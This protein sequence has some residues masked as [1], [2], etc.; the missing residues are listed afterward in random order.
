VTEKFSSWKEIAAH[1]NITVRTAQRW[2]KSEQLPVHRHL[3]SQRHSVY[4]F[5]SE[6]DEWWIKRGVNL[7]Q[8]VVEKPLLRRKW[9]PFAVLGAVTVAGIGFLIWPR[10]A[11]PRGEVLRAVPL[12]AYR[13]HE[14][15]P[16][17]S[18]DASQVAFSWDE[19]QVGRYDIFVGKVGGSDLPRRLTT[20]P[21]Q[22]FSP[23]WSPDG[24]SI[25]FVRRQPFGRADVLLVGSS[26]DAVERKVA[27]I[28][29]PMNG[30]W[31]HAGRG[32][33]LAWSP[34]GQWL[35]AAAADSPG[36]ALHLILLSPETGEK[37]IL[38][39]PPDE[40][41]G[42][43]SASFSP[44]G[45]TLAFSRSTS[46]DSGE[47]YLLDLS[48]EL[49]PRGV[50]RQLTSLGGYS[51][52][53]VWTS[54]GR[55]IVFVSGSAAAEFRLWMTDASG[56]QPELVQVGYTPVN[57]V[58]LAGSRLVFSQGSGDIDIWSREMP[59]ASGGVLGQAGSPVRLVSSS[60]PEG[61]P[62]FSPD[63][64]RIAFGSLR[65][66]NGEIY[67]SNRDGSSVKQLTTFHG[68][69]V[70]SLCWSPNGK[71]LAFVVSV[72]SQVQ[73]YAIDSDGGE[74]ML[75]HSDPSLVTSMGASV[76]W[77]RDGNWIYFVSRRSGSIQS[78][79]TAVMGG[80]TVQVTRNGGLTAR[81]SPDGEFVYFLKVRPSGLWR[82]PTG[83]GEERIVLDSVP[84][85]FAFAEDGLHFMT[86]ALSSG[87]ATLRFFSFSARALTPVA[88]IGAQVF[89]G[90]FS[91]SPDRRTLVYSQAEPSGADLMLVDR[92]R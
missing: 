71:R 74:P 8:P 50:P 58:A 86:R 84:G 67:V 25:A 45:R 41:A 83:G 92:F 6:L 91:V 48:S 12:T 90:G 42:D 60:R 33:Y 82:V 46:Q 28:N 77:S 10:V 63:G 4:A 39:E 13:G 79:K 5:R 35:A 89:T 81:E 14:I 54:D 66:G 70:Q 64:T 55:R 40:F 51:A 32:R 19:E 88:D 15:F 23:A 57:S 52:S 43:V 29:F 16:A 21:Q 30:L 56:G 7:P 59:P 78:W 1:L 2:E 27:E 36:G 37:R 72:N 69:S 87:R 80:A 18:P 38:T 11:L 73:I 61:H 22:D 31:G 47:I 34:D 9:L 62:E 20:D 53:P 24:L 49:Q 68:P 76:S 65:S 85:P 3:H 26:G 17:L 44:D 75:I